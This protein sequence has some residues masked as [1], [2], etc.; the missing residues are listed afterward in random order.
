[1][2]KVPVP[3]EVW[4]CVVLLRVFIH[5][6]VLTYFV[7]WPSPSVGHPTKDAVKIYDCFKFM[8]VFIIFH[9]VVFLVVVVVEFLS[10]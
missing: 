3:F 7:W 2:V 10:I 6:L 4:E 1:M 8:N 9:V 5:F